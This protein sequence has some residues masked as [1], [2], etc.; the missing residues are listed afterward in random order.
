[1]GNA[2]CHSVAARIRDYLFNALVIEMNLQIV[3]HG[4]LA[5]LGQHPVQTLDDF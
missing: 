2:R 5:R 3:A 4:R 1:M